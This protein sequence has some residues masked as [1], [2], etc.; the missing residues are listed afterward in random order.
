MAL[1]LGL[2]SR[3]ATLPVQKPIPLCSLHHLTNREGERERERERYSPPLPS[4]PFRL[5]HWK[6]DLLMMDEAISVEPGD[7]LSGRI[8][9]VRNRHWRRHLHVSISYTHRTKEGQESKV[10]V[11]HKKKNYD[12]LV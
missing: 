2:K 9:I 5:T 7:V 8:S 3:L 6:Q 1:P 12:E 11:T 4:L 10:S